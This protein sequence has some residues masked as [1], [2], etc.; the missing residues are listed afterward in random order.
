VFTQPQNGAPE[1]P[2]ASSQRLGSTAVSLMTNWDNS[3]KGCYVW[4][5]P[6]YAADPAPDGGMGDDK[7]SFCT[8]WT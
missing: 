5:A 3:I 6:R 8:P 2:L 4:D 1:S 7:A